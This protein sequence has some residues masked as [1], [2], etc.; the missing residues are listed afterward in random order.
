KQENI[1]TVS[2]QADGTLLVTLDKPVTSIAVGQAAAFY[3]GDVVLG[4]GIIQSSH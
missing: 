2:L 4:G 3:R 1:G